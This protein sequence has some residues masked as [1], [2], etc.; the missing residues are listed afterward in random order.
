MSMQLSHTLWLQVSRI[1]PFA[2]IIAYRAF[3]L[4]TL[5][6]KMKL[7]LRRTMLSMLRPCL[8]H[9][10]QNCYRQVTNGMKTVLARVRVAFGT[11]SLH[12]A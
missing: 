7:I 11:G 3:A 4:S 8:Q 5:G 12:S 9:E 2:I 10:K 6:Y 1:I